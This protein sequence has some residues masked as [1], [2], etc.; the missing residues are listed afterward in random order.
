MPIYSTYKLHDEDLKGQVIP[1]IFAKNPTIE[2]L[3]KF[4]KAHEIKHVDFTKYTTCNNELIEELIA[5]KTIKQNLLQFML[6]D[7]DTQTIQQRYE[8]SRNHL[9]KLHN[10]R[11][12]ALGGLHH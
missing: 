1:G 2:G 8:K 3:Q 5:T 9:M 10:I 4:A 12:A 6:Q 7:D 11:F